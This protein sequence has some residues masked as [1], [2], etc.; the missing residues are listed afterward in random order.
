M[1]P[2][3]ALLDDRPSCRILGCR[4]KICTWGSESR[5]YPH[6]EILVGRDEMVR[7]YDLTH[8]RHWG[9]TD[10]RPNYMTHTYDQIKGSE[11]RT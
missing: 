2:R 10:K 4:Y 8:E 1:I 9:D 3:K 11:E 7:R 6:E 5:C